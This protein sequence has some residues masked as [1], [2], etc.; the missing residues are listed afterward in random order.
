MKRRTSIEVETRASSSRE[1]PEN[2][3]ALNTKTGGG[4]RKEGESSNEWEAREEGFTRATGPLVV[5]WKK[6][7]M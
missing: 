4:K 2:P 6:C 7:K 3:E 1:K 5:K